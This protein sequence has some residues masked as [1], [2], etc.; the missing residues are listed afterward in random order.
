MTE[1]TG[2]RVTYSV[3][4]KRNTA[5][6]DALTDF[7]GLDVTILPRAR[8][9]G[10]GLV[11]SLTIEPSREMVLD[12]VSLE[13]SLR[14]SPGDTVYVNGFQ[15]WTESREFSAAE[16]VRGL[17][18]LARPLL[19]PYGDYSFHVHGGRPGNLHGWTYTY[20]RSGRECTLAG[21]L[22]EAAGYTF[23]AYDTRA[24]VLRVAKDCAGLRVSS[25]L[26]VLQLYI[27]SGSEDEV[28]NGY[29]ERLGSLDRRP[30][31]CSGWTSWYNYYTRINEDILLANL[32][33]LARRGIPI[34][35]FQVDDG[36]EDA[37]GDWLVAN[38]KFPRGMKHIADEVKARGYKA[39]LWL[40]PF[41]C[42]KRSSIF[43]EHPEW[44]LRDARGRLVRAGFNPKWSG[45]FFA[46]DFYNPAVRSYLTRVFDTVLSAWGFDMVKLDF[47][48]AVALTHRD[49]K[50]RG[51]VMT[52]ALD[53]LRKAVGD[54]VILGCGVPLGPAFSRV[55]YCRVG[56][57][58][59]LGWEDRF[60]KW[61]GYRERVSTANAL[62]SVIGRRHLDGRVFGN[63]P[64]VFILR[65]EGNLLSPDQRHTLFLLNHIFGTLVFT[66]DNVDTYSQQELDMYLS[67][68][69]IVEK[70][71]RRVERTGTVCRVEF[72]VDDREYQA[73]A[74][75]GAGEE[76]VEL[77]PGVYFGGGGFIPGGTWIKL[78]QYQSKC[79]L[80]AGKEDFAVVGSTGHLF[81]GCEVSRITV[82]GSDIVMEYHE[83]AL[84]K[85]DVYIRV[86]ES[87]DSYRVNGETV[88]PERV[89]GM[90][91]IRAGKGGSR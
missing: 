30:R 26:L 36:Y 24:G 64:D 14:L 6:F 4:G 22:S 46:L 51:Q 34:D 29:F 54:K 52:E 23:F 21:S 69:P 8:R 20:V 32:D 89:L 90:R 35:Y 3:G 65:N 2:G 63:D 16:R 38:R 75:L 42:E 73:F 18:A 33:A 85:R 76:E 62:E 78:G 5:V 45:V 37:V 53:F 77:G 56:S 59:A 19:G 43:R 58:V 17:R 74:N 25:P 1:V 68:F 81:P 7:K 41:V 39:G 10:N 72:S 84:R 82:D 50:P 31:P 13:T 12:E 48:Y 27:A 91:V 15:S 79:F 66:S 70:R 55:D 61:L 60:L 67:Q 71:V 28:F 87:G 80:K 57:D 9:E 40:A 47:L 86:P 44:L 83:R 88:A 11:F 49:G